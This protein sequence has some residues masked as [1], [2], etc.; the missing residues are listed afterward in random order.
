MEPV[1][2]TILG[3][4]VYA[5]IK[6]KKATPEAAA[7]TIS[8]VDQIAA[9]LVAG[10]V[11][12]VTELKSTLISQI[13]AVGLSTGGVGHPPDVN[14]VTANEYI[15]RPGTSPIPA[16][17]VQALSGLWAKLTYA[18]AVALKDQSISQDEA[19]SIAAEA[20]KMAEMLYDMSVLLA[21]KKTP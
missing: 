9:A 15:S 3:L 12:K 21:Q 5:W 11:S 14:G 4:G 19:L 1:T 18:M 2:L 10:Q 16:E 13:K 20:Q 8:A 7:Q 6:A 17:Q